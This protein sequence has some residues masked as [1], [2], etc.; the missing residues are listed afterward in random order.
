MLILFRIAFFICLIVAIWQ[1]IVVLGT[2]IFRKNSDV[3]WLSIVAFSVSLSFI[4]ACLLGWFP[5]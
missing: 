1:G 3:G 5:I 2:V 4:I